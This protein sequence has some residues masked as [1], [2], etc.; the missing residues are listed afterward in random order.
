MSIKIAIY[1]VLVNRQPGI[2]VRY[3]KLHNGSGRI[4]KILSW[5]YLLWLNFAFY[6]LQ[7]RFLGR[8]PGMDIYESKRLNCS[9]SESKE[10]L[11]QNP[12]LTVE[13]FVRKLSQYDVISFD[14]FDTLIFRPLALPVDVFHMLGHVSAGGVYWQYPGKGRIYRCRKNIYFKCVS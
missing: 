3:H 6:V 5:V 4:V 8:T 1:N 11:R 12:G 9:M 2:S 10:H 14:V 13:N 7:L